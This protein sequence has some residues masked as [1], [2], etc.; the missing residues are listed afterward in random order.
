MATATYKTVRALERGLDVLAAVNRIEGAN[1]SRIVKE[2]GMHRATVH[3]LLKTL[4][5]KGI[6]ATGEPPDTFHV[7]EISQSLSSGYE[8]AEWIQ[9]IAPTKL[10]NLVR[11]TVWPVEISVPRGDRM[12]VQVSTHHLTPMTHYRGTIGSAWPVMNSAIGRA[13][14]SYCSN[15]Q[16][17]TLLDV[18]RKSAL[19]GNETAQDNIYVNSLMQETRK[20]GYGSSFR[21]AGDTISAIALPIRGPQGIYGC[22]NMI[23][24][25]SVMKPAEAA[26]KYLPLMRQAQLEIEDAIPVSN[27]AH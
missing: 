27:A 19:P 22:M 13:Y 16:R 21:E 5:N 25:A 24:F 1:V 14:L 12:I 6:I 9:N 20:Q 7:T 15:Q 3:R 17:E 23:F 8:S 4:L 10:T 11:D 18:L 26:E 2:T